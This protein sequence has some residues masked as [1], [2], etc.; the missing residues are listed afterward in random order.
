MGGRER[1][2]AL[3]VGIAA[4]GGG[5]YAVFA[6]SNQAGTAILLILSAIF[7]LIGIQG[8]S[9]IRFSTGSNT[10]ELEQR[11][12]TVEQA[13]KEIARD[14]P[15]RAAGIIEG[16]EL[17]LPDLTSI[18][19]SAQAALLAAR[20]E[21]RLS[22]AISS[23]G[24]A[25]SGAPLNSDEDLLVTDA[26]KR[27]LDVI[28]KYQRRPAFSQ[29][30]LAGVVEHRTAATPLLV[31]VNAPVSIAITAWLSQKTR[32][33][34]ARIIAWYDEIDNQELQDSLTVLFTSILP[35]GKG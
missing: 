15:E 4:G 20:Y 16:A 3:S 27:S 10:V 21:Q 9:L 5:G 8:T 12:R 35:T 2:V 29:K 1:A 19:S 11:R 31:V 34:P 28:V 32:D 17:A 7:L 14:E 22:A 25:V 26:E 33:A 24:Y 13:V 23:M 18:S 6:S 30:W